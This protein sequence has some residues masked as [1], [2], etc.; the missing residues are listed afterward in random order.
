MT[1]LDFSPYWVGIIHATSIEGIAE[2]DGS[3]LFLSLSGFCDDSITLNKQLL[4]TEST[5]YKTPLDSQRT[6]Q[7]ILAFS[8]LFRSLSRTDFLFFSNSTQDLSTLLH[9]YENFCGIF[10]RPTQIL[11]TLILYRGKMILQMMFCYLFNYN[12]DDSSR[13]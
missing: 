4:E 8:F 6:K 13:L 5:K 7:F 10:L 3:D 2:H 1:G 11:L 12:W 9:R